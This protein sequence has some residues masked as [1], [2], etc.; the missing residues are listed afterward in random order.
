MSSSAGA[1]V[2]DRPIQ[3]LSITLC[4]AIALAMLPAAYEGQLFAWHPLLLVLGFLG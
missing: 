1:P 3:T 4:V 2:L